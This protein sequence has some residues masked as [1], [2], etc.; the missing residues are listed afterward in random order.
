MI[1]LIIS[2]KLESGGWSL[3]SGIK[4]LCLPCEGR[5]PLDRLHCV[6]DIV[7]NII[8]KNSLLFL[9]KIQTSASGAT[10][11]LPSLGRHSVFLSP[12]PYPLPQGERVFTE[13]IFTYNLQLTTYNL[14]LTTYN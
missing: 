7:I 8:Q 11:S 5:D 13:C 1:I 4:T 10:G 3:E 9:L 14:Q 6:G 12:S 2:R